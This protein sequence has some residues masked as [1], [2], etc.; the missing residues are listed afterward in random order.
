MG[1]DSTR[2]DKP[3]VLK[4]KKMRSVKVN[5]ALNSIRTLMNIL[6]P[7]ITFPYVT[8]ILG[9]VNLGKINY[10]QSI[11][12]YFS[13]IAALGISTY[14]TRE[15]ARLRDYQSACNQFINEV[16]TMNV[17][18]TAVSYGILFLLLVFADGLVPYRSLILILSLTVAFT[19]I[20][21]DWINNLF[22]D[23][24]YITVRSIALQIVNIVL[25]FIL[26]HRRDDYLLYAFLIVFTQVCTGILNVFYCRRYCKL[27]LTKLKKIKQHILPMAVF[28]ANNLAVTVYCSADSTMLGLIKGDHYVGIYAV[29]TKV[30]TMIRS[31]LASVF[32][33]CI[34]R[35][36]NMAA[37]DEKKE[38]DSL[39]STIIKGFMLVLI[40]AVAGLIVLARP[41]VLILSGQDFVEAVPTLQILSVALLFAIFG[42]IVTNCINIPLKM[43]KINLIATCVAAILNIVL[44]IFAIPIANQNGAAVTT[45]I[46]EFT[47]I[48]ICVMKNRRFLKRLDKGVFRCGV[49]SI[50][51][52][53]IVFM[54]GSAIAV[55]IKNHILMCLAT[56]VSSICLYAGML[57]AVKEPLAYGV[58]KNI[59]RRIRRK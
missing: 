47:V 25:L 53:I 39:L 42:G 55:A 41:I 18:T 35:L 27:R 59:T 20:G 8:R 11:V 28:F 15:G 7:L 44:N 16:F 21:V 57:L 40:P 38:F 3:G 45:V 43:E 54:A 12:S 31:L 33:V 52:G 14:A 36:S 13:L 56:F 48:V 26:I 2:P 9:T 22:E 23:Y 51:G 1:K 49:E 34:P 19:T 37:K 24:Y 10:A 30:Y 58:F 17:I 4:K 29:A 6:F 46:A 5:A 50:V 32:A